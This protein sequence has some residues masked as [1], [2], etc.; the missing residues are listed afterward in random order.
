MKFP[1]LSF[2]CLFSENMDKNESIT[3]RFILNSHQISILLRFENILFEFQH[4]CQNLEI[5]ENLNCRLQKKRDTK[6]QI[7][8]LGAL[9]VSLRIVFIPV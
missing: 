6:M 4:V 7:V 3:S 1:R 2:K 9:P 8:D 5:S